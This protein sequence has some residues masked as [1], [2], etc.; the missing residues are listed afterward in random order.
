M[1]K[2]LQLWSVPG[3][4]LHFTYGS[5]NH[6]VAGSAPVFVVSASLCQNI[7]WTGCLAAPMVPICLQGTLEV[8]RDSNVS[9]KNTTQWP[10]PARFVVLWLSIRSIIRIA[11][12]YSIHLTSILAEAL[13]E[14]SV[15][16]LVQEQTTMS[17][18]SLDRVIINHLQLIS[19]HFVRWAVRVQCLVQ[20]HDAMTSPTP[21]PLSLERQVQS[22]RRITSIK[23]IIYSI[24]LIYNHISL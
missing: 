5:L 11:G 22:S 21:D 19:T 17:L 8:L 18:L 23:E 15:L 10:Y 24:N 20:G 7:P 2:V 14:S 16:T 12:T 3:E 9:R 4:K 1:L 6:V 13:W